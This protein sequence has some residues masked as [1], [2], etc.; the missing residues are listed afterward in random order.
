MARKSFKKGVKSVIDSI[1][2]DTPKAAPKKATKAKPKAAPKV[3][4]TKTV[5]PKKTATRNMVFNLG[6][7]FV[8]GEVKTGMTVLNEALKQKEKISITSGMVAELDVSYAQMIIAFD[9]AAKA[10]NLDVTWHL[11]FSEEITK[12][13]KNSGLCDILSPFIESSQE[14]V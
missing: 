9:K 6:S 8:V 3:T 7:R 10:K 5:A 12:I 14:E 4:A 11:K 13:M 2:K 1:D